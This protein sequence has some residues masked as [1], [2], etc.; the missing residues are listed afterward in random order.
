M[1][2]RIILKIIGVCGF[3]IGLM[4]AFYGFF[5][6][7]KQIYYWL[8]YGEWVRKPLSILIT[9]LPEDFS[10][11]LESPHSWLGVHEIIVWSLDKVP[12]SLFLIVAGSTGGCLFI[13]ITF[14]QPL[15]KEKK[16]T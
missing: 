1:I 9:Y 2:G 7:L 15:D 6:F 3:L 8:K 5:V 14:V 4:T 16:S 12:F 11:W 13:L 10:S